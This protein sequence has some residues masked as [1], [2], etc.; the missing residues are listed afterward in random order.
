MQRRRQTPKNSTASFPS[1]TPSAVTS[2]N[3]SRRLSF[4]S[5]TSQ[6]RPFA[7]PASSAAAALPS[8]SP[9]MYSGIELRDRPA[10]GT[11]SS[12]NR[13]A[14]HQR[15]PLSAG[16]ASSTYQPPS[17]H[18]QPTGANTTFIMKPLVSAMQAWSCVVISVFAIIILSIMGLLFKNNHHEMVGGVED[19]E[20][21]PEVAA[22]IFIAVLIY[23]VSPLTNLWAA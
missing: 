20:N 10:H 3:H 18:T 15:A 12:I 11:S 22:T 6:P 13:P 1:P 17:Y 14:V 5:S 23:A 2:A 19:P 21:G 8:S 16:A 9:L 4:P 7:S